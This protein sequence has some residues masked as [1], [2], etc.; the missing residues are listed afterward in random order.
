LRPEHPH[1]HAPSS[2]QHDH[3]HA[4]GDYVHRHAHGHGAS[5]HGHDENETPLGRLDRRLGGLSLYQWLRPLVVGV[6]HGLAG[7]AAVALLV[8]AAVPDPYF[9]MAY[10]ALFGIG[11][12]I[13]MMAVT[14]ALAAPFALTSARLPRFNLQLRIASGLISVGFGLFLVYDIGFVSGGLFTP[15]PSWSP[16]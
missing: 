4:H 7:S 2:V 12:V 1:H 14:M 9:A 15:V 3:A 16:H 13:G 11:T 5:G 10:L 8:L 6:V